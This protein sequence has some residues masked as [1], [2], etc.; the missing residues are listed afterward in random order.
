M[1]GYVVKLKEDQK[2]GKYNNKEDILPMAMECMGGIGGDMKRILQKAADR[3]AIRTN[4]V[5]SIIMN[6]LRKKMVS[7][8]MKMNA[9]MI[10]TSLML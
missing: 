5:Y 7:I 2:R 8:L 1:R 4:K 6:Q 9:K 3:I 10:L